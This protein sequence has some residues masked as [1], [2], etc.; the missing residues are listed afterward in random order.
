MISRLLSR[1]PTSLTGRLVM[2]VVALVAVVG[3][4]LT[5][6]TTLV[7]R[8]SLYVELDNR[9]RGAQLATGIPAPRADLDPGHG[10][11]GA[12]GMAP[13]PGSYHEPR[14]GDDDRLL[15]VRTN[16]TSWEGEVWTRG[17]GQAVPLAI[18]EAQGKKL[19]QAFARR[20]PSD[21]QGVSVDLGPD[22]GTYRFIPQAFTDGTV[23]AA[24]GLPAAGVDRTAAQM[25]FTQLL[26][27][28]AAVG[29]A[30]MAGFWVVR[31][32]LRPL[33][34]VAQ[35]A[36][37]VTSLPLDTGEVGETARVPDRSRSNR[38]PQSP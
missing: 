31:R 30:G 25:L 11:E 35:T 24:S 10:Q 6:G 36:H 18:S 16:G 8:H 21:A 14:D 34:D 9:I 37:E 5:V 20:P 19:T 2:A 26:L 28:A 13:G 4:V 27:T 1:L 3:V 15:Q 22:Y 7:L 38:L 33:R 29:V 12:E 17:H 23:T 32:T